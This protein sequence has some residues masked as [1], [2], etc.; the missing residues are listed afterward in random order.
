MA[1]A[2]LHKRAFGLAVGLTM[3]SAL[4]LAT[5]YC[6]LRPGFP[7]H[8]LFLENYFPG[9]AVSWGG[10][11]V[12]FLWATFSFS[13]AGWFMGFALRVIPMNLLYYLVG[14]LAVVIALG[15][16]V[17]APRR[18]LRVDVGRTPG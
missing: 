9:Y 14:V 6:V 5:A 12:G 1:F 2:P 15:F 10:A 13:V 7:G 17:V 8:V 16:H 3:G 4:F 18:K 11:L